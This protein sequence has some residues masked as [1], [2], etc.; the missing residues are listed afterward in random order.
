M[1][2][3]ALLSMATGSLAALAG[4]SA[5]D[6][7][8]TTP[9]PARSP[10]QT[11]TESPTEPS[12]TD[13]ESPT[14]EPTATEDAPRPLDVEL[15]QVPYVAGTWAVSEG[16][17]I[18]PEDIVPES[19]VPLVLR[20]ALLDARD[21]AWTTESVSEDLLA[22]IETFRPSHGGDL[23]P[24]VRL[25]GVDYEFTAE[26]PTFVARLADETV[27]EYDPQRVAHE[28]DEFES[29]VVEEFVSTL[30]ASGTH[31]PRMDY[32]RMV[33]PD[34]VQSFL[35]S[36]DYLEDYVGVSPIRTERV[37]AEPPHVIEV[38]EL[39][40]ADMWGNEVVDVDTLGSEVRAF[41]HAA[42]DSDH[43]A[44]ATYPNRTEY[45]TD[46]VPEAF[47]DVVEEHDNPYFRL[48]GTVYGVG[49]GSPSYDVPLDV[50]VEEGVGEEEMAFEMTLD[51]SSEGME[52]EV[53]EH[54][55][56]TMTGNGGLPSVLWV[57]HDGT[58]RLLESD[59]YE[60]EHWRDVTEDGPPG[61]QPVNEVLAS[62]EFHEEVDAT[63]VVPDGL[64]DGTY[65]S[66]GWFTVSWSV[67][68]QTPGE[69]ASYP[70]RL[71]ITLARE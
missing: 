25:D 35:D 60:R 64:P 16:S 67:P 32:R 57:T 54:R 26:V 59:A 42:I 24:Y 40:A 68:D 70:F 17:G 63:Y 55:G 53:E 69:Y 18:D 21:G 28:D 1:R 38:R 39:T 6:P 46:H 44:P 20:D 49:A 43:R 36:Y 5:G 41:I 58:R 8:S 19:E 56:L 11:A 48:D 66:R 29:E 14:D 3:R 50:L 27:E 31:N 9:P 4:C 52:D 45:F 65:T 15:E 22:A 12:P 62:I 10:T 71:R 13:L 30:V 34:A 37:D 47:F 61:R 7:P 2:R 33:V 23:V 51:P